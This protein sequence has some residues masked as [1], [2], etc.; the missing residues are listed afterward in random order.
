M[1]SELR[2][3]FQ[4]KKKILFK[5]RYTYTNL[6]IVGTYCIVCVYFFKSNNPFLLGNRENPNSVRKHSIM[7]VQ[8]QTQFDYNILEF[9]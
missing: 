8:F 2:Y 5:E 9:Q 3:L 6:M 7:R 1:L 4:K